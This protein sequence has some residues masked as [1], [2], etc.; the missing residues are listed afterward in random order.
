MTLC[1]RK[2]TYCS[3][4]LGYAMTL[5][6][7]PMLTPRTSQSEEDRDLLSTYALL[8]LG[9]PPSHPRA[10]R[11]S[12]PVF[13]K[14]FTLRAPLPGRVDRLIPVTLHKPAC[15]RSLF[16]PQSFSSCQGFGDGS[17]GKVPAM[18]AERP[19]VHLQRASKKPSRYGG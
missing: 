17:V 7:M 18:Q 11:L 2:L 10:P 12:R 1:S 16:I 6:C 19:E 15:L 3:L 8:L 5:L 13:R 4:Y 9:K 14:P